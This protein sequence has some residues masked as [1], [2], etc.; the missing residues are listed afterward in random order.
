M[1]GRRIMLKIDGDNNISL[2]A[3]N[4][5]EINITPLDDDN[6]PVIMGEGD[7]IIFVVKSKRKTIIKKVFTANM[8]DEEGNLTLILTPEDTINL[9]P[10]EYE[11]DC[12]YEFEDGSAYTFID[13]AV[14][15]IVKAISKVGDGD[16]GD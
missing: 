5:G 14:F 1:R 10:C 7:K 8:Q 2:T 9:P 3:G 6:E 12:L 11:Y 16:E 15:R 13:R 4:S